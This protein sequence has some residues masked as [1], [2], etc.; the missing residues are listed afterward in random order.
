MAVF[1]RDHL[2]NQLKRREFFPVYLL[3]G[4]E[5]YVRDIAAKTIADLVLEDSEL[6]EFNDV[7]HSL[8]D[9]TIAN[10]LSDAEQLPLMSSRRVVKIS[11]VII[12][13]TGKNENI[14]EE[15]EKPLI[16][17]L[18]RPSETSVVIFVADEFDKRRRISKLL[19]EKSVAI[20][21]A[22]LKD[23]ELIKWVKTKL[24]QLNSKGEE[25]AIRYLVS[26]VGSNVRRLSNEIEKLCSAALPESL[27]TYE[28][29]ESLVANSREITNFALTD[30]LMDKNRSMTLKVLKKLLD[31]GAEP[32]MLLG[33]IASNYRRLA[34]AKELMNR[35]GDKSSVMR[36]ISLPPFMHD[37]FLASARRAD[38][39]HLSDTLQRIAETDL[40]I[41]TSKAG[42]GK[43]GAQMQIEMLVCEL[44]SL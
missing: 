32:L 24:D 5:T 43:K 8:L 23:S 28:L 40:A 44:L 29:V 7:E 11:N 21:F 10:A 22:E 9:S 31:D 18:N 39:R 14:S 38:S 33:L 19:I 20:E 1:G 34:L 41:K 2:R 4:A 17:Y 35:G 26:L 36:A 6:R 3:F 42:G 30:N 25:K 37:E 15:D 27:I 16:D 12:S 13:A